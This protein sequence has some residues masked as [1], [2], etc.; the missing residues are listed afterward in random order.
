MYHAEREIHDKDII[1]AILDMCDVQRYFLPF[2]LRN[3]III[4]HIMPRT[5]ANNR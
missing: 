1:K 5:I 2:F 4:K 3:G